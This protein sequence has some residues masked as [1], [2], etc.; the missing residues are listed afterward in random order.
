VGC[1]CGRGGGVSGD[2]FVIAAA[3]ESVLACHY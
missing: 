3:S 2:A 1:A